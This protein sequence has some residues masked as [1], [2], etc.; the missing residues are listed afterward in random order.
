[1]GTDRNYAPKPL[2]LN[3]QVSNAK[4]SSPHLKNRLKV[5]IDYWINLH[6]RLFRGI[7]RLNLS[8]CANSQMYDCI[9]APICF[10]S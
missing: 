10:S 4:G 9:Q 2:Y 6:F 7:Q 5:E 8:I 1:M 3:V